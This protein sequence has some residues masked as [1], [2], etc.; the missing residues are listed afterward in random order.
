MSK[1][2]KKDGIWAG[3]FYLAKKRIPMSASDNHKLEEVRK[4]L[5]LCLCIVRDEERVEKYEN[6]LKE[7]FQIE[8]SDP[9]QLELIS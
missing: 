3:L 4:L 8:E 2:E 6:R 5:R 1:L 9:E 7:H